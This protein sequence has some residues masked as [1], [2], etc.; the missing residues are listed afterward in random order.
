MVATATSKKW[1][2]GHGPVN[3]INQAHSNEW[4]V[5]SN[6]G[7]NLLRAAHAKRSPS[8]SR[9][10]TA[11][12]KYSP[13]RNPNTGNNISSVRSSILSRGSTPQERFQNMQ[14]TNGSRVS[15]TTQNF[16][17]TD[18]L[19]SLDA[20]TM[21]TD[22]FRKFDEAFNITLR[23]NPTIL[24]GAPTVIKSIKTAL[25]KVQQSKVAK[26]A[27]TMKQLDQLK[28][29]MSNM[30]HKIS[31]QREE[32]ARKKEEYSK[33]MDDI[34]AAKKV[35]K[36]KV[37]EAKG[38]NDEMTKHLD[39]LS[40]SRVDVEKALQAEVKIVEK[41]RD[42]L[43]KATKERKKIQQIQEEN[44]ILQDDVES[45]HEE[46]KKENQELKEKKAELEKLK[47]KN[48]AI[49]NE[50]EAIKKELEIEQKGLLE[51]NATMKAKKTALLEGK[52]V[53]QD[54]VNAISSVQ[55]TVT[56][57]IPNC[58]KGND[59]IDD[60]DVRPFSL[61]NE[62]DVGSTRGVAFDPNLT[63]LEAEHPEERSRPRS[64]SRARSRSRSKS[65]RRKTHEEEEMGKQIESLR[66]ELEE[67]RARNNI[68]VHDQEAREAE[69]ELRDSLGMHP[70][71]EYASPTFR[72][73]HRG[74][75][76]QERYYSF[77]HK[78]RETASP[79]YSRPSPTWRRSRLGNDDDRP[80][81]SRSTFSRMNF[82][83]PLGSTGRRS[84]FPYSDRATRSTTPEWRR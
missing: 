13:Q 21:N 10:A 5:G 68:A 75:D 42:A 84:S 72:H 64:R 9:T 70:P 53:S 8:P 15:T 25:F 19:D 33:E 81:S 76:Q 47:E 38:D 40:K 73:S 82:S 7:S 77:L 67:V 4:S 30:D 12:N 31:Q 60:S 56:S 57:L 29:E 37:D 71:E 18:S 1:T 52:K 74:R 51:M 39:F 23:N 28:S 43:L 14:K 63:R 27:E 24:P 69:S 34:E 59:Q 22:L 58:G 35:L 61:R 49:R 66:L 83:S 3:K 62:H 41:E 45:M 48:K 50:T 20:E 17:R 26:E 16:T 78:D 44:T 2:R 32:L 80:R 36:Q 46:A 79:H 54:Q 65:R 6:K 55:R 11:V